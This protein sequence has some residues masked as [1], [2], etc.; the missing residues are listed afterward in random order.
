[1]LSDEGHVA[2]VPDLR[3]AVD[4]PAG[5]WDRAADASAAM[6]GYEPAVVVGHSGAGVLLPMIAARLAGVRSVVFVDAVVPART[7]ATGT[8]EQLRSFLDD[9][10]VQDG[11]LPRWS[12]W[13]SKDTVAKLLPD[14]AQREL[15]EAEQPRLA[16]SFYD[17]AV[18]VPQVW[19]DERVGYLQL[20]PAY[21]QAGREAAE[22]GWLVERLDGHHLQLV[23][24]PVEVA[25]R[26][27][28]LA[29][30]T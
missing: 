9:L 11:L 29:G 24:R 7:G 28:H 14:P 17:L 16:R 8:S 23:T 6:A 3:C 20:S 30:R 1:V 27:V 15:L 19:P 10:P 4:P 22:R 2:R 13:W 25:E 18:P 5:W 12:Q 21:E 26:I